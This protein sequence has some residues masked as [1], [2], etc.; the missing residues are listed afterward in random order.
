MSGY[1]KVK[2]MT[3][4]QQTQARCEHTSNL[5]HNTGESAFQTA[6]GRWAD[7]SAPAALPQP[8]E[9]QKSTTTLP[10]HSS[11]SIGIV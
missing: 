6:Q 3:S 11:H 7:V 2:V 5:A 10:S 8:Q 1:T 9:A 4:Q